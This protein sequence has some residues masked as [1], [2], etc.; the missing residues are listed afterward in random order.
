MDFPVSEIFKPIYRTEAYEAAN[1][2]AADIKYKKQERSDSS[3]RR[4]IIEELKIKTNGKSEKNT[5]T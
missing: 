1:V 2:D 4:R 3:E 5:T